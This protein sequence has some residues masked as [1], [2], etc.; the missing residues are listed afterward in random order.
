MN[1][2]VNSSYTN[3]KGTFKV[4]CEGYGK[5]KG[6]MTVKFEDGTVA[7]LSKEEEAKKAAERKEFKAKPMA[8]K[9]KSRPELEGSYYTFLGMLVASA[10]VYVEVREGKTAEEFAAFYTTLKNKP[11]PNDGSHYVTRNWGPEYRIMFHKDVM[12][13]APDLAFASIALEVKG[14]DKCNINNNMDQR[15]SGNRF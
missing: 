15:A 8:V 13:Y 7:V 3:D 6:K 9:I 1:F 11:L 4:I 14:T 12:K 10:Y 2:M 5:N